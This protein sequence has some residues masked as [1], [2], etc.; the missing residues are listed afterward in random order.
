MYNKKIMKLFNEVK[1]KFPEVKSRLKTFNKKSFMW[2][3]PITGD[4]YYNEEQIRKFKFSEDALKGVFAH[5]LSHQVAYKNMN[6]VS[7]ILFK[8]R[9]KNFNYKK[10]IE[11]EADTIT[12]KRGFG[13]ELIRLYEETEKKFDKKRALKIKRTHLRVEEIRDVQ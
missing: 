7:R 1:K 12:V 4:I 3:S 10:K 8:L 9:Y 2:S 5:E 6:F 11:R 13:K